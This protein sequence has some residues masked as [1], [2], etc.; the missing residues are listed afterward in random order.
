M[1]DLR[2]FKDRDIKDL[3]IVDNAITSF[4]KHL[5]NGIYVPSFY[6]KN[7]DTALQSLIPFLKSLAGVKDVTEELQQRI[8]L[9]KLYEWYISK[10]KVT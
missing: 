4:A 9:R 5:D 1:K 3:I 6:G 10:K 8:R 2:I 7:D